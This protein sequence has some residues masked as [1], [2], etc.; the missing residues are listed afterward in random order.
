MESIIV[1]PT[2]LNKHKED[3]DVIILDASMKPNKDCLIPKSIYFD[4]KNEFSDTSSEF[5]NTFPALDKFQKQC[6]LLG[7]N[8]DSKIVIYD[9]QGIFS[10]PRAWWLLKMFGLKQVAILDGGIN[11]WQ[12]EGLPVVSG[13]IQP[14]QNGNFTAK[15]NPKNIKSFE[16]IKNNIEY[17]NFQTIDARSAARYN[18][19]IPETRKG[20]SSGHIP[21]SLNLPFIDLLNDG[22]FKSP[23]EIKA[24]F[25]KLNLKKGPITFS[26]G[27]GVTAC[28]LY[29]ASEIIELNEDKYIYDGSWTE[30]AT[31]NQSN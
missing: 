8:Q 24:L 18:G 16:S 10:S 1:T 6:R 13:Y 26:C 7:I 14:I 12:A 3:L 5:P 29:M 15:L 31:K 20:L 22:R 2:W 27:S 4:I 11:A 28:I 30:W 19:E 9:N 17:S 23:T 25:E 21:N